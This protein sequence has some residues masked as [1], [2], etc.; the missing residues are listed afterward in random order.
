MRKVLFFSL[1]S[2]LLICSCKKQPYADKELL[3]YRWR[4]D[5]I[6]TNNSFITNTNKFHFYFCTFSDTKQ[7]SFGDEGISA[8][9]IFN[10]DS[11]HN[12]TCRDI[13]RMVSLPIQDDW[14]DTLEVAMI[15]ANAYYIADEIL[16][17]KRY[18]SMQEAKFS[19]VK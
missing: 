2:L 8:V 4:F 14:F 12:I 3:N 6:G 9:G 10:Y 13:T 17:V 7:V 19:K 16:T 18:N 1:I 5:S 11:K 15:N